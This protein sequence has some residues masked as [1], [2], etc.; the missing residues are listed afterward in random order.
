MNGA[1][2]QWVVIA[3]I[4]LAAIAFLARRMFGAPSAPP[5]RAPDVPASALVRKKR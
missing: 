2:W 3:V 4:E 5:R 1:G